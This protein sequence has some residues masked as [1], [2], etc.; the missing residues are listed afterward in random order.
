MGVRGGIRISPRPAQG[1]HL[2]LLTARIPP[3]SCN[4]PAR[5]PNSMM[6]EV[7]PRHPIPVIP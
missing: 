2:K 1:R 6:S 3:N 4:L 7:N 5:F